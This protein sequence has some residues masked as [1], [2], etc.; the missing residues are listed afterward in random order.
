MMSNK[1]E[2][3]EIYCGRTMG[4]GEMDKVMKD[5]KKDGIYRR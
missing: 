3:M 1:K 5:E 2:N 4:K